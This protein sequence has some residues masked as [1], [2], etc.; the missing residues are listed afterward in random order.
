MSGSRRGRKPQRKPSRAL[1]SRWPEATME[2]LQGL[3][4]TLGSAAFGKN[5]MPTLELAAGDLRSPAGDLRSPGATHVSFSPGVSGAV[6]FSFHTFG[7]SGAVPF[8]FLCRRRYL[9]TS[10]LFAIEV[11]SSPPSVMPI[12][13][14]TR[15]SVECH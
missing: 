10:Q 9:C 3:E 5:R 11:D 12:K 13:C 1:N 4:L 15:P 14:G 2:A 6:S 8:S 7:A